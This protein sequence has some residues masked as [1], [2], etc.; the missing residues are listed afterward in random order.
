MIGSGL[1][2]EEMIFEV[3]DTHLF[4]ND[5]EVRITVFSR[6]WVH[7][8][9]GDQYK[10]PGEGG[11][12]LSVPVGLIL[13]LFLAPLRRLRGE[14]NACVGMMCVKEYLQRKRL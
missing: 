12:K 7:E 2:M 9:Q 8:P 3:A 14:R 1:T 11:Y 5:L 6:R 13:I 4:F 10:S